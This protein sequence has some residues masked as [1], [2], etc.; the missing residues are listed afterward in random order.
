[1]PER[2]GRARASTE[3]GEP[4][5]ALPSRGGRVGS[6]FQRAKGFPGATSFVRADVAR[7]GLCLFF[8]G[9]GKSSLVLKLISAGSAAPVRTYTRSHALDP[10]ERPAQSSARGVLYGAMPN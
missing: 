2:R 4:R 3:G 1:M 9:K 8:A 10:N 7:A 5:G 6:G